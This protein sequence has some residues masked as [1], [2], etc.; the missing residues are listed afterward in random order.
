MYQ[1][2]LASKCLEVVIFIIIII[3]TTSTMNAF[4]PKSLAEVL[5]RSY[6]AHIDYS[7]KY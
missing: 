2:I 6:A 5:E 3:I 4:S 1:N 7:L